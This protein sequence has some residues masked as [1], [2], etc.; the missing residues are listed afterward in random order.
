MEFK[1][2]PVVYTE[3]THISSSSTDA[4]QEIFRANLK[5]NEFSC[6]GPPVYWSSDNSDTTG[7]GSN[8]PPPPKNPPT[9][10]GKTIPRTLAEFVSEIE[11]I[12][13]HYVENVC[14]LNSLYNL[15]NFFIY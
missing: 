8:T 14:S 4:L 3:N 13:G 1:K 2:N 12:S 15:Q 6:S 5:K 9:I 7:S 10:D 11:G